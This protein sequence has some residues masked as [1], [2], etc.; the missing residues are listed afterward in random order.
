MMDDLDGVSA[1]D[2][3]RGIQSHIDQLARLVVGLDMA[4]TNIGDQEERKGLRAIIS[5]VDDKIAAMKRAMEEA[6]EALRE[7]EAS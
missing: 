1:A 6:Q 2:L 3:F 5:V 4:A 7:K